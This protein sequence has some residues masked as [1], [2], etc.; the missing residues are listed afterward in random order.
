MLIKSEKNLLD[1]IKYSPIVI[2]IFIAL[3]VNFLIYYQNEQ[4]IKKDLEIYKKNYIESNKEIVKIHVEKVFAL[5]ES[6]KKNLEENLKEELKA[7]VDEAYLIIE[8]FYNKYPKES[9]ENLLKMIKESLRS[10]R[11]NEGRSY[12]Y[13]HDFSG[14]VILHPT[15][16]KYEGNNLYKLEKTNTVESLLNIINT[17]KTQKDIYSN[18]FWYKPD[19]NSKKY[20]K[21]SY[22]RVFN[23]LGLIIG[24]G[25]YLDDFTDSIK[26]HILNYIQNITY[27]EDG[28]VFVFDYDGIQ[29]AHIKKTYLGENRINLTDLKGKKITQSIINKAK[30][31]EG[32]VTYVGTVKPTTGL[33]SEKIT[34]VRGLD[35][36]R[37]AIASGFYTNDMMSYLEEK[38]TE[39]TNLNNQ[40]IKKIFIISV[41][42][43]ILLIFLATHISNRLKKFFDNYQRRIKNEIQS[44]RK[45]DIIL[46][47]Q[48]KMA[49]MGEM[50]GNIAHQWRQPLN[51]I[52]TAASGIKL[53][54]EL[55]I[56]T[57]DSQIKAIDSILNSTKYLSRTIDDFRDFFNPNKEKESVSSQ[58]IYEKSMKVI[59]IRL[60]NHN[61]EIVPQIEDIEI[62]TFDN[63][64]TQA[65]INILN[66][67]IDALDE[68]RLNRK[69]I[70]FSIEKIEQLDAN[71]IFTEFKIDKNKNY[72]CIKIK[73]NAGGSKRGDKR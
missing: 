48:S 61:I 41:V 29:L 73:D 6:Q 33:P 49:A 60:K 66:N 52:S 14:N 65:L 15:Y 9:K 37:W 1:F 51:L 16:P 55:G 58:T 46:Y 3:I 28:Y 8:N 13:L 64:L 42:L 72:A 2:I 35:N 25:E 71:K 40:S 62:V 44:N 34:Y 27:G 59:E 39:L 17:L 32:F 5:I 31:A 56:L 54:Q 50:I 45:K 53:E 70:F 20:E 4:N 63:E 67:A 69:L 24:T 19:D 57:K 47:Q 23:P 7:K 11:F 26:K 68:Q 38:R 12:F 21:I 36:W 22:S 43:C 18:L 10:I 30:E